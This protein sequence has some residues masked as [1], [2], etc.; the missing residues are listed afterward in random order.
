[1]STS[2]ICSQASTVS[3][4]TFVV[5]LRTLRQLLASGAGRLRTLQP[6]ERLDVMQLERFISELETGCYRIS[7]ANWIR[8]RTRLF[9]MRV[10]EFGNQQ[11][12]DA[13]TP[14]ENR[15]ALDNMPESPRL[16]W[17]S[18]IEGH[19]VGLEDGRLAKRIDVS[20]AI[21][22]CG[23]RVPV[24]LSDVER[25]QD[26]V[27]RVRWIT[28]PR[29]CVVCH[30]YHLDWTA[31]AEH[32]DEQHVS[33]SP[34]NTE[35]HCPK[36]QGISMRFEREGMVLIT[37]CLCGWEGTTSLLGLDQSIVEDNLQAVLSA[38]TRDCED[39][40]DVLVVDASGD[41]RQHEGCHEG[42]ESDVYLEEAEE[43]DLVQALEQ[44][45]D[46]TDLPVAESTDDD[47]DVD[48]VLTREMVT[49]WASPEQIGLR[50]RLL[51]A[52]M[53]GQLT[54]SS[55]ASVD[56]PESLTASRERLGLIWMV[57]ATLTH[58]CP[59]LSVD[60]Q[61]EFVLWLVGC[62]DDELRQYLPEGAEECEL[63]HVY[64]KIRAWMRT[65]GIYVKKF[66][67]RTAGVRILSRQFGVSE[68]AFRT[69]VD[70]MAAA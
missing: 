40:P 28:G 3:S 5:H 54:R 64:A 31:A 60:E 43:G 17:H 7:P 10:Q 65:C 66:H 29:Q 55:S 44:M 32:H 70:M 46:G 6:I 35:I 26:A 68:A 49:F 16:T 36:C 20:R 9:D 13:R 23:V 4:S 21:P 58:S 18:Y 24:V 51:D 61:N 59:R 14:D 37:H 33:E 11:L 53:R 48:T 2:T 34:D 19:V 25:A 8:V 56:D 27:S 50:R 15:Y 42:D 22:F 12:H 57:A 45:S 1:M 38:P 39:E 41:E 47:S 52:T 62:A 69:A 67:S 63:P 30:G